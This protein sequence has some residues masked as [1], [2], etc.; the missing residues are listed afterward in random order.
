MILLT[1]EETKKAVGLN[2]KAI[3]KQYEDLGF[4]VESR[5][6]GKVLRTEAAQ[7][8][9]RVLQVQVKE[10]QQIELLYAFFQR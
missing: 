7:P 8:I 1:E 4:S 5:L 6:T 3:Q 2:L 10:S 9:P